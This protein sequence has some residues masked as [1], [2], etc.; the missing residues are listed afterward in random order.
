LAVG[1]L[2][3][4]ATAFRT[5][6]GQGFILARVGSV[7]GLGLRRMLNGIGG[8]CGTRSLWGTNPGRGPLRG[9]LLAGPEARKAAWKGGC[10]RDSLPHEVISRYFP[11]FRLRTL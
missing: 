9:G 7:L 3:S 1:P 11:P 8:R 5:S 10:P 6:R 2:D 4:V